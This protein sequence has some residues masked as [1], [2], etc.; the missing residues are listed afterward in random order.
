MG[1]NRRANCHMSIF[2]GEKKIPMCVCVW[3]GEKNTN[4]NWFN[5]FEKY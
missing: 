5:P 1:Q 4:L 3:I 2:G